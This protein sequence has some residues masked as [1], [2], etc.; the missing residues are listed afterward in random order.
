MV[1]P[2]SPTPA[3]KN[4]FSYLGLLY[5]I[6]LIGL[7]AATTVQLGGIA[8]RRQVEDELIF[9]GLQYKQAIRAYFEAAPNGTTATAPSRL[10]D[11]LRD[12]RFPGAKRHL[13]KLYEDPLTGQMDWCLIKT[14]DGRGILGIYSPSQETPIRVD[15]FPDEVFHFKGKTSYAQ[16]VFVYGVVCTDSGCEITRAQLDPRCGNQPVP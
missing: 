4:G 10:E 9:V 13:R 12:P 8:Q 7:S 16:W 5:I 6:A 14:E 15:H 2:C 1:T 11:L 3:R